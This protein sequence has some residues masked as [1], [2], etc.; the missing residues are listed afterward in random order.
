MTTEGST[1][2]KSRYFKLFK[3][4]GCLGPGNKM[5]QH[6]TISAP[7]CFEIKAF[8]DLD[9]SAQK[10]LRHFGTSIKQCNFL[11]LSQK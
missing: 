4:P 9:V 8:L 1:E 5:F 6:Q 3:N 10:K 7:R 11:V 2:N